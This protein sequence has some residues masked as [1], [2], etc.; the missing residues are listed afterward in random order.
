MGQALFP[1]SSA[2]STDVRAAE[3]EGRMRDQWGGMPRY[4][5]LVINFGEEGGQALAGG[6]MAPREKTLVQPAAR[7]LL[8]RRPFK[9]ELIDRLCH[10]ADE[11][12]I[13]SESGVT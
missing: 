8:R 6:L 3:V 1:F 12:L 2:P 5:E 11:L 10:D 9:P 4:R 13:R 7:W